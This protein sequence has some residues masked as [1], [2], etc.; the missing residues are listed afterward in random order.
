MG[1]GGLSRNFAREVSYNCCMISISFVR[2][3]F[4]CA[5]LLLC[6]PGCRGQKIEEVKPMAKDAHPSYEVATIKPSDPDNRSQGFHTNGRRIFIE[7]ETMNSLISFAYGVHDKQIVNAP[8]WFASQR[9]DIQ[10]TADEPGQPGMKQQQEML[11]KLLEE[12]FK[13]KLHHDQREMSRYTIVVAKG[14]AKLAATKTGPEQELP[15]QTGSNSATQADWRFTNNSMEDFAQFLQYALD[16]PVVDQ[17]GLQGKFD[18]HLKWTKDGAQTAEADAPPGFFTAIQ[19]QIGLKV[20]PSRGAV[21]A[22]V[23]DSVEKPVMD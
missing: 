20:E 6:L 11:R 8:A 1:G 16:R 18:F 17:T 23:V 15:D 14:G 2:T 19:E 12:R 10:G 3:M 4:V 7:N 13:L 22:L 5:G 21:D 9:F